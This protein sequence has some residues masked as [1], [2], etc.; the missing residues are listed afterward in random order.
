MCRK[1]LVRTFGSNRASYKPYIIKITYITKREMDY[2]I[3]YL[4]YIILILMVFII[5]NF[6]DNHNAK[7]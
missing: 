1:I 5:V 7:R 6:F 4:S 2:F 3:T